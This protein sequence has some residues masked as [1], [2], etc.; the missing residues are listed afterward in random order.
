M[1]PPSHRVLNL[2]LILKTEIYSYVAK[3]TDLVE[4]PNNLMSC[5]IILFCGLIMKEL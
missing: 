4:P 2:P 1:N 5:F 3:R